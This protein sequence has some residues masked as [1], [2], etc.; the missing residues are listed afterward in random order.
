[1]SKKEYGGFEMP[2]NPRPFTLGELRDEIERQI[3]DKTNEEKSENT[4]EN[5]RVKY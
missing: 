2:D 3:R 1:M 4:P 5:Q